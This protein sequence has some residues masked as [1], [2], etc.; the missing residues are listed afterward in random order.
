ME[1]LKDKQNPADHV[2]RWDI[3]RLTPSLKNSRVHSDEQIAQI[4]ASILEWGW[5]MPILSGVD[6]QIIAGHARFMAAKKLGLQTVPVVVADGW[7][8]AQCRAYVIADNSL[9]LNANWDDD[10]LHVEMESLRELDFDISLL[11]LNLSPLDA[12]TISMTPENESETTHTVVIF[13]PTEAEQKA[14]YE[15]MCAEGYTCRVQSL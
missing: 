8:D 10:M 2:S 5:T 15:R 11:G 1:E 14:I 6:G 7:T 12:E 13:C 4:V 3:G 9:A